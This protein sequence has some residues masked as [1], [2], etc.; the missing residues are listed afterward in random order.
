VSVA[1]LGGYMEVA[2]DEP[3]LP[4]DDASRQLLLD[5]LLLEKALYELGYELGSRPDWVRIPML[6]ILDLLEGDGPA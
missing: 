1:F 3:F 4:G 2:G 6:G 5:V